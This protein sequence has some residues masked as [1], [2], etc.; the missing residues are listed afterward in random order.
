L[1][2]EQFC[3]VIGTTAECENRTA[4]MSVPLCVTWMTIKEQSVD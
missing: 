3:V 2:G 1:H 4:T